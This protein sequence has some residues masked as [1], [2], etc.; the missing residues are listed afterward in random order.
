MQKKEPAGFDRF[1]EMK[2]KPAGT[3]IDHS[4]SIRINDDD[5]VCLPRIISS[6][7]EP[8]VGHSD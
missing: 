7:D 1:E 3:E 2:S 5:N 8:L 6:S 4:S